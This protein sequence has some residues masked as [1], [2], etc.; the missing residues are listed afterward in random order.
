MDQN[1]VSKISSYN[2]PLLA[3]TKDKVGR[4]TSAPH[5]DSSTS[6]RERYDD[7][8]DVYDFGVILLEMILGRPSKSR[9]QV[10][11]LKKQLEAITAT[12]DVMR[13]LV[14]DPAVRTSCSDQSLKTM[15]EICVR[16]LVKNPAERP[17]VDDVL[18]NLQFAA[19]V[20]DAW[21]VDSQSSEGSP[22][23]PFEP[24]HRVAFAMETRSL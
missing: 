17:S 2:L 24:P 10:Q 21:K 14:A 19:Q 15:M 5:K 8:S 16:C 6:T 13:R 23:S 7:E 18:W 22:G 12:D 20:Q 4:G 3:E 11:I 1:L 9:K